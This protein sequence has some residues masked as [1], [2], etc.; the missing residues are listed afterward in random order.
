MR[1]RYF[2]YKGNYYMLANK[3][4]MKCTKTRE[5]VDAVTYVRIDNN[6]FEQG[7]GINPTTNLTTF[8]R[9]EAEFFYRFDEVEFVEKPHN[10]VCS[11]LHGDMA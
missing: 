4:S 9:P 10:K 1:R 8:C 3:I 2:R 5:W 11:E 6:S 7:I